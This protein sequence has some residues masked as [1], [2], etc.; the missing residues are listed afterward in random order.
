MVSA[1]PI[2]TSSD[3]DVFTVHLKAVIDLV[4]ERAVE[5][6]LGQLTIRGYSALEDAWIDVTGHGPAAKMVNVSDEAFAPTVHARYLN[7]ARDALIIDPFAVPKPLADAGLTGNVVA[8]RI[9]AQIEH[10]ERISRTHMASVVVVLQDENNKRLEGNQ[11]HTK[12][13]RG[14]GAGQPHV[15]AECDRSG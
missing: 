9:G 1:V 7:S 11:P 2:P 12:A 8:K 6:Q 10:V 14:P 3:P 5:D 4:L 13:D 15:H